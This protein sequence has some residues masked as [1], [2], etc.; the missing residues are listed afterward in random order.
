MKN[1]LL[2]LTLLCVF[3]V[4]SCEKDMIVTQSGLTK[5]A[6]IYSLTLDSYIP[7]DKALN[8]EMNYIAI[9]SKTLTDA[10]K[11]DIQYILKYFEK[12]DV[13]VIDKS[14]DTLIE[15]G[16]TIGVNSNDLGGILLSIDKIEKDSD[17]KMVIEGSKFRSGNGVI[18]V[19]TILTNNE[20][21]NVKES[22]I[23]WIS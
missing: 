20:G 12:Y 8:R 9:D 14:F 3:F 5:Y 19:K 11:E 13:N 15:K 23:T 16:M 22:N 21:W 17:E 2:F 1:I 18:G 10:T 7:L 6:K 4:S